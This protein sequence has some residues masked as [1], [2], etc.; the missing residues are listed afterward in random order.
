MGTKKVFVPVVD[1]RLCKRCGICI[2]FCP[3]GIFEPDEQGYPRVARSRDCTGCLMC[4]YRCPD[5][6]VEVE[7]VA[8][9][10]PT[11]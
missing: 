9:G 3:Q 6:A 10:V 4:F 7:R 11:G 2:R 1:A 8:G 5:F